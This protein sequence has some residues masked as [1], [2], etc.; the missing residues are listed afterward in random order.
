VNLG[1]APRALMH[2]IRFLLLAPKGLFFR[3]QNISRAEH[4]AFASYFGELEDHPVERVATRIIPASCGSTSRPIPRSIAT[5]MLGCD[6]PWR[7]KLTL[8]NPSCH[9]KMLRAGITGDT[10]Y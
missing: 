2:A 6:A 5:R 7:E 10:S 8:I 9:R 4:V 3:D 1:V